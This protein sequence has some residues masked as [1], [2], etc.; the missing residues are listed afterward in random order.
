MIFG[1]KSKKDKRIEEL[2]KEVERLNNI[3][4]PTK[5]VMNEFG[6]ELFESSYEV[7]MEDRELLTEEFIRDCLCRD[8]AEAMKPRLEIVAFDDWARRKTRFVGRVRVCVSRY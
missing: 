5:I 4:Q 2:E 7:Y 1:I 3:P 6:T 8:L